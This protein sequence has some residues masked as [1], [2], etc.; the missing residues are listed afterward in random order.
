MAGEADSGKNK[1]DYNC[2]RKKEKRIGGATKVM[3]H[4]GVSKTRG[5]F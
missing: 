2:K 1:K 4:V 3:G 5:R